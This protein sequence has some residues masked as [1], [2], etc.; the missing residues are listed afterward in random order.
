MT[1]LLQLVVL[2]AT[3][4]LISLPPQLV[5][6]LFGTADFGPTDV[7]LVMTIYVSGIAGV[8]VLLAQAGR[9]RVKPGWYVVAVCLPIVL[10][11]SAIGISAALEGR[12]L[13]HWL[14][15]P[16]NIGSLIVPPLGEEFGWRG[17]ALPR[18][19]RRFNGLWASLILGVIWACW[20]IPIFFLPG[21]P[22]T[23]FPL[24]LVGVTA[25]SILLTWLYNSTGNSLLI[26]MVAHAGLDL[27]LI[28]IPSIA[29]NGL[30]LPIVLALMYCA[31]AVVV[32]LMTE[33]R[34]L[35]RKDHHD[36]KNRR[37]A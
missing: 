12:S 18:L 23:I 35:C 17:F 6:V 24:F 4:H 7:A 26:V 31:A 37:L 21:V 13:A 30:L 11:L 33:P 25:G 22:L 3:Y 29:G 34:T 27:G 16:Q 36:I 1:W 19:Q 14:Q 28:N 10:V 9:W 15:W 2:L 5:L 8:G 20:H 32:V